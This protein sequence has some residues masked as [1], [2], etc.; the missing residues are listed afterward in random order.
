MSNKYSYIKY[1]TQQL[2][3]RMTLNNY[4]YKAS[5]EQKQD[6]GKFG[7]SLVVLN[8]HFYLPKNGR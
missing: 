6:L 5:P 4:L 2:S 7:V 3:I 1:D 8:S